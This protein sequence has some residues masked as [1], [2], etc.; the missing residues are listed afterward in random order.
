M[1]KYV[2]N[3]EVWLYQNK[4]RLTLIS[5][6]TGTAMHYEGS[7]EYYVI[8][9]NPTNH[10]SVWLLYT[11]K[12]LVHTVPFHFLVAKQV[13]KE[14]WRHCMESGI[15]IPKQAKKS[16]VTPVHSWSALI[17][18]V[19]HLG[20]NVECCSTTLHKKVNLKVSGLL[21]FL[22]SECTKSV[23]LFS[24]GRKPYLP[25]L[26]FSRFSHSHHN[27]KT[28]EVQWIPTITIMTFTGK[29]ALDYYDGFIYEPTKGQKT[30][31]NSPS[32]G[33]IS[34]CDANQAFLECTS[35][36]QEHIMSTHLPS[37]IPSTYPAPTI[38]NFGAHL[39]GR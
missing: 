34:S 7:F 27:L 15:V 30:W 23:M 14:S 28:P 3:C 8:F 21:Y 5:W 13:C 11:V 18:C 6:S 26:V 17:P 39:Y 12:D 25:G 31:N 4:L 36:I 37:P 2:Q 24:I 20:Q 9:G 19:I 29:I 35:V 1:W 33:A 38:S 22:R 10:T 16:C 32:Y